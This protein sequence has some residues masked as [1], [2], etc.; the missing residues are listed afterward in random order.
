MCIKLIARRMLVACT[1]TL[2]FPTISRTQLLHFGKLDHTAGMVEIQEITGEEADYFHADTDSKVK[3]Q[4]ATVER[5][6]MGKTVV[7]NIARGRYEYALQDIKFILRYFPN[8]PTG[9]Q[10]LTSVAVLSKNKAVPIM[11]F[12][13]A[14]AL[15][16]NHPITYAQYG[17]YYVTIDRLDNGI[18]KLKHAIKMD[19][20][21]TAAYVW[22]AQAYEKKG[23][24]QLAREAA[25]RA[26]ELGYNGAAMGD[27]QK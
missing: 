25:G 6:H 2:A 19:P 17:W 18:Q 3:Y 20:K 4:L 26:K 7:D 21:L 27:P 16:P 13:K 22:L 10:L 23:E 15:Y 14:I 9:L 11:Y 5:Y 8:H 12:E 24:I 1:L